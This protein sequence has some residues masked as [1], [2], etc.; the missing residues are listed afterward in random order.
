MGDCQFGQFFEN[1]T[2]S[3]NVCATLSRDSSYV[4]ILTKKEVR[5]NYGQFFSNSFGHPG[6]DLP[7]HD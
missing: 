5:L 2:S 7:T 6:S 1:Y 4:L 3:Q